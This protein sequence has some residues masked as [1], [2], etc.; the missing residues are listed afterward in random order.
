M[1]KHHVQDCDHAAKLAIEYN[2]RTTEKLWEENKSALKAK[3]RSDPN[4]LFHGDKSATGDPD[5]L[6]VPLLAKVQK[7][8]EVDKKHLFKVGQAPLMLR[9][10]IVQ[11]DLSPAKDAPYVLKINGIVK[12]FTGKT[13]ANGQ[14]E[15]EVPD[16]LKKR[17]IA[18]AKSATLVVRVKAAATDGPSAAPPP[19]PPE[20]APAPVVIKPKPVVRGDIPCAWTLQ[21]GRLDPVCEIAPNADCL[22]G[23]QQRL[24][25]L[26]INAGPVDGLASPNT[27]AA[28]KLFKTL[29]KLPMTAT[30]EGDPTAAMQEKLKAVHDSDAPPAVPPPTPPPAPK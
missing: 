15:I 25:N 4:I 12:E 7:N 19:P 24:N 30:D 28:I 29:Y 16:Y 17:D 9:L 23:V 22:S 13:D 10:R 20:G 8:G 5:E 1:A 14:I 3:K 21:I 2:Y 11:N 27:R 18:Y 6:T 26:N